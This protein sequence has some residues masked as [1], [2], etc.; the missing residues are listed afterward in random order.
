MKSRFK[1]FFDPSN[2]KELSKH[3]EKKRM[4]LSMIV[5]EHITTFTFF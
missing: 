3:I 1:S 2:N 4:K 5:E